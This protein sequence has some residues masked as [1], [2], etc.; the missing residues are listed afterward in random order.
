M[1]HVRAG[2]AS[3]SAGAPPRVLATQLAWVVGLG[4]VSRLAYARALRV[5]TVQGG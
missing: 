3:M 2:A 4:L 1:A 5:V